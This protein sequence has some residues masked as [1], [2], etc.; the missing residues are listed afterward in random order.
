MQFRPIVSTCRS[1]ETCLGGRQTKRWSTRGE[2][3]LV[4]ICGK[5]DEDADTTRPG[6]EELYIS[7]WV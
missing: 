2:E 7:N 1:C 4:N 3:G 5:R 6:S